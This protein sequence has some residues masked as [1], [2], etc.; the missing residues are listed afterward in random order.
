[1]ELRHLKYFLTVAEELNFSKAAERLFIS[2]PPLS[3]QI[4]ELEVELKARLFN[5]NNKR[6]ELTD[7]GKYFQIEALKVLQSLEQATLKTQKIAENVSGEFRIAYISSTLSSNISD[8]LQYL[9]K[10]YPFASFKLFEMGTSRQIEELEQ[11]KLD[12][13]ILRAPVL[14]DR[15]QSKKWFTDNYSLV[16]NEKYIQIPDDSAIENL[17]KANFVFFN[18]DYAPHY[19]DS[20]LQIC[21]TYGFS[22]NIVHES[23]NINSIIQ[24]VRNGLGVSIVPSRMASNTIYKELVFT[25]LKRTELF[26]EVML[27]TPRGQQ[28]EIADA[29]IDY[30]MKKGYD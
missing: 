17:G 19:H 10:L 26:T 14:S 27:A 22:P 15:I 24:L 20:L 2:Q 25:P 30:L 23:N 16:Y 4:K 18:K 7:A 6:V 28:S 13:G 29:G 8:L 9:T 11:G 3:R 21:A 1:M 5:R 12:L